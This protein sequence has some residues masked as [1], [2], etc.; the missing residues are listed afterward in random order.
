MQ[1]AA[2]GVQLLDGHA[3]EQLSAIPGIESDKARLVEPRSAIDLG[4]PATRLSTSPCGRLLAA[5]TSSHVYVVDINAALGNQHHCQRK[6]EYQDA[7]SL[8]WLQPTAQPSQTLPSLYFVSDQQLFVCDVKTGVATVGASGVTAVTATETQHLIVGKIDG[9]VQMMTLND[10]RKAVPERVIMPSKSLSCCF[11]GSLGQ[12]A[13][14]AAWNSDGMDYGISVAVNENGQWTEHDITPLVCLPS[15]SIDSMSAFALTL[16]AIPEWQLYILGSNVSETIALFGRGNLRPQVGKT[17]PSIVLS[18]TNQDAQLYLVSIEDDRYSPKTTETE[19][20]EPSFTCGLALM[21]T[22]TDKVLYSEVG[23]EPKEDQGSYHSEPV[24]NLL[25]ACS[26]GIVSLFKVVPTERGGK[27]LQ[28]IAPQTAVQPT[29]SSSCLVCP[30]TAPS[31][32]AKTTVSP[33]PT[34]APAAASTIPQGTFPAFNAFTTG[35][36]SGANAFN[37]SKTAGTAFPSFPSFGALTPAD[38]KLPNNALNTPGST[39][40]AVN[41]GTG[42]NAFKPEPSFTTSGNKTFPSFDAGKLQLTGSASL[43]PASLTVDSEGKAAPTVT[44]TLPT[45]SA[46][47]APPTTTFGMSTSVANPFTSVAN[48][49]TSEANPPKSVANPFSSGIKSPAVPVANSTTSTA[50]VPSPFPTNFPTSLPASSTVPSASSSA[51]SPGQAAQAPVSNLFQTPLGKAHALTTTAPETFAAQSKPITSVPAAVGPAQGTPTPAPAK[52]S[53]PQQIPPIVVSHAKI[54]PTTTPLANVKAVSAT[55]AAVLSKWKEIVERTDGTLSRLSAS[56]YLSAAD[57]QY[58][59]QQYASAK[60]GSDAATTIVTLEK[61][62][63]ALKAMNEQLVASTRT[64]AVL[65]E[66]RGML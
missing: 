8:G 61:D 45:F 55:A 16:V 22:S 37:T 1:I 13:V 23:I 10:K 60:G 40:P 43:P 6:F 25:V 2:A 30:S 33:Q 64:A 32:P 21:R 57:Q 53:V 50:A 52:A 18:G 34:P 35:A 26:H 51:K 20:F 47:S 46:F 44:A 4:E 65:L 39:T 24:P 17:G 19:V 28:E 12:N 49:S 29:A 31:T 27:A 54:T 14:I 48:A 15:P 41:F 11:V 62:V 3:V 36:T 42:L 5:A 56:P 63:H 38:N 7:K 9:S 58:L 66:S 59:N